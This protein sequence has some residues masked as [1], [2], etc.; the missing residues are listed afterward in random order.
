MQISGSKEVMP[1]KNPVDQRARDIRRRPQK[2]LYMRE[3][4]K[5]N[6]EREN[7]RC[8]QWYQDNK[9]KVNNYAREYRKTEAYRK[10]RRE[11]RQR[12]HDTNINFRIIEVL[13]SRVYSVLVGKSKSASTLK[14]LGCDVT[15]LRLYLE[16]RFTRGMNWGNFGKWHVDHIIPLAEFDLIKP[17][18]QRQAFNYSNLQPL[19]GKDNLSKGY[20]PPAI[21][22][23]EL[24]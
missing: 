16:A 13:R 8:K 3:Y 12:K 17:E 6:R 10:Y 22:Q 24:L 14:L 2:R 20:K 4:S 21:H 18:Q 5:K 19:W 15:F 9:E 7:A 11:L 23:A 1:Y